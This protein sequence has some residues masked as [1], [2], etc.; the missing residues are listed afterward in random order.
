MAPALHF[1]GKQVN[2]NLHIIL[3]SYKLDNGTE[4]V[5]M[6]SS[7]NL[8]DDVLHSEKEL[9]E[10]SRLGQGG[11]MRTGGLRSKRTPVANSSGRN[12]NKS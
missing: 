6:G 5:G 4:Q 10:M 2:D 8:V 7:Q 9:A 11:G 1:A 12:M 3:S